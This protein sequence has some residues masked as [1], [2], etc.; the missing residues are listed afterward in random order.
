MSITRVTT[1]RTGVAA[2]ELAF[3]LPIILLMTFG[4]LDVCDGIFLQ[5]KTEIAAH[6]GARN[7]IGQAATVESVR[8]AVQFY[9]DERELEFD[10][11]VETVA[12]SEDPQDVAI[13]QP[14]TVTVTLDLE[15]NR[16]LPFAPFQFLNG[17]TINAQ[18]TMYKELE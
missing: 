18:V 10:D 15:S 17:P 13:L 6:E 12:V 8:D 1:D 2:V 5:Q 3:C 11:I 14:I 7:A 4:T 9:L 16:R